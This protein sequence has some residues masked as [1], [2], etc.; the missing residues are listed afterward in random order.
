MAKKGRY[1]RRKSDT[2]KERSGL[3]LGGKILVADNVNVND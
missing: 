2:Q 1:S 3:L